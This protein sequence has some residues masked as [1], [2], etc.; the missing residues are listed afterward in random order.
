VRVSSGKGGGERLLEKAEKCPKE[1]GIQQNLYRF[2][3][4]KYNFSIYL[5][6]KYMESGL[7]M[8]Y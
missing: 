2:L 6:N 5:M 3:L 4:D 7:L 1:E 8:L